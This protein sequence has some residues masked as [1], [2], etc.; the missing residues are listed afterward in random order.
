[1][2]LSELATLALH[3]MGVIAATETPSAAD[4]QFVQ[5][6]LTRANERLE[7]LGLVS[8]VLTDVPDYI[9]DALVQYAIPSIARAF[10]YAVPDPLMSERIA[11]ARIR[12]LVADRGAYTPGQ[13]VYF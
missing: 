2:N 9:A 4:S 11:L 3:D 10:G 8:W 6:K 13:A 12:E 7:M 5:D 1:M